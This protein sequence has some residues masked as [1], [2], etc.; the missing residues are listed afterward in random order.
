[1]KKGWRSANLS[2]DRRIF[3]GQGRGGVSSREIASRVARSFGS[4]G[5]ASTADLL[6]PLLFPPTLISVTPSSGPIAGG[7]VVDLAGLHFRSGATATF[8]GVPATN[9][10]FVSSSHITCTVPAHAFGAVDVTVTNPDAQTST[11]IGGYTYVLPLV[12]VGLNQAAY[13]FDGGQTWALGSIPAGAWTVV[14]WAADRYVTISATGE[15]AFTLNGITWTAGGAL[16]QPSG[17]QMIA[18][19]PSGVVVA[20]RGVNVGLFCRSVDG[21]VTWGDDFLSAAGV[22]SNNIGWSGS[23][24]V[25]PL[26]N[27]SRSSVDGAV[28]GAFIAASGLG[29]FARLGTGFLSPGSSVISAA[30][31]TDVIAGV[32]AVWHSANG[33]ASWT[34]TAL[35]WTNGN[36][37]FAWANGIYLA[38]TANNLRTAISS[39]ATSWVEQ[40]NVA[41]FADLMSTGSAFLMN[42]GASNRDVSLSVDGI[43]W[44]AYPAALP[45]GNP[46]LFFAAPQ[47]FRWQAS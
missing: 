1:M 25:A 41:A 39:D 7:T 40:G 38:A 37:E 31:G 42:R 12:A 13:S 29:A 27:G 19:N 21:G 10:V 34:H 22:G 30:G 20:E 26:S 3:F 9:A 17:Y 18:S 32:Q 35:P 44:T 28:W 15:S 5:G 24:F 47:R 2:P 36:T 46:W 33:G 23:E 11:L 6:F 43:T 8:D 45:A 4:R 16:P 14:V